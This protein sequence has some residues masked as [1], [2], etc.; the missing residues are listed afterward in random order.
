MSLIERTATELLALQ[1]KAERASKRWI[2][3]VMMSP[4]SRAVARYGRLMK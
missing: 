1:A 3:D 2:T 4:S